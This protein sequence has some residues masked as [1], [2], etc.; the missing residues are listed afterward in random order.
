[1]DV[2]SLFD[3]SGMLK[4]IPA[5]NSD[6]AAAIGSFDFRRTL[7]KGAVSKIRLWSKLGALDMLGR[8]LAL[9]QG[10]GDGE[11]DGRLDEVVEAI[12]AAGKDK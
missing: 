8:Y 5:L 4:P 9:W 1:M 3:K 2:R 7:K 12:R 10:K 11:D 6:A